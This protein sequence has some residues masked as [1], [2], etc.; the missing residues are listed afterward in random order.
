MAWALRRGAGVFPASLLCFLGG[1]GLRMS[2]GLSL[3]LGSL[4]VWCLGP[5]SLHF[6]KESWSIRG[7][8]VLGNFFQVFYVYTYIV[9]P[10]Y[11][12][13]PSYA[14][15][16]LPSLHQLLIKGLTYLGFGTKPGELPSHGSIGCCDICTLLVLFYIHFI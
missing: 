1:L 15:Q 5:V 10:F 4:Y 3:P 13:V 6:V 16:G 12:Y 8:G 2:L 7:D 14:S 11:P 9:S